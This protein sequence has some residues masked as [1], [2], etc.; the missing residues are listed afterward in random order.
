MLSG[1]SFRSAFAF[2]INLLIFSGFPLA[3]FYL[4]EA[5]LL[6][7]SFTLLFVQLPKLSH[8]QYSFC[9]QPVLFA[10]LEKVN[11]FWDNNCTVYVNKRSQ[12]KCKP[13]HV[14]FKLTTG[15]VLR[16]ICQ[17]MQW[18]AYLIKGWL[19]Y[20]TSES[21]GRFLVNNIVIFGSV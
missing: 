18:L 3:C 12:N 10:Q 8:F 5:Y 19:N 16:F 7:L 17:T 21:K 20:L 1:P 2:N 6:F 9:N 14:T 13:S 15:S 4:A 11:K